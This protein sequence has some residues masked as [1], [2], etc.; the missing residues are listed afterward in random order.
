MESPS[1]S[2]TNSVN[3][4]VAKHLQNL[5]V[6]WKEPHPQTPGLSAKWSNM[7]WTHMMKWSPLIRRLFLPVFPP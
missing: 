2:S 7:R 3:Y 4:N 1:E 5:L 6:Y